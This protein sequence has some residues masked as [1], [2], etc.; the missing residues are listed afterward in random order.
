MR[1]YF[2]SFLLFSLKLSE[3][4]FFLQQIFFF[5]NLNSTVYELKFLFKFSLDIWKSWWMDNAVQLKHFWISTDCVSSFPFSPFESSWTHP[6][7]W[8]IMW[9]WMYFPFNTIWKLLLSKPHIYVCVCL[10]YSFYVPAT[11]LWLGTICCAVVS[12][13]YYL[14]TSSGWGWGGQKKSEILICLICDW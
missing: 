4:F 1:M 8:H 9:R 5:Y 13:T 10:T 11:F 12:F 3:L 6:R 14:G 2:K 7:C